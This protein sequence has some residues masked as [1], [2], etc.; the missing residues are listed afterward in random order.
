MASPRT[1]L[2]AAQALN[3]L[4]EDEFIF[5]L[6]RAKMASPS[7]VIPLP[8]GRVSRQLTLAEAFARASARQ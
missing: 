7:E 2:V 6:D 1:D 4:G 3:L 8:C 5:G